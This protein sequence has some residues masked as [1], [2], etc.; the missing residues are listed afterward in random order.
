MK[1]LLPLA[2]LMMF[3][4]NASAENTIFLPFLPQVGDYTITRDNNGFTEKYRIASINEERDTYHVLAFAIRHDGTEAPRGITNRIGTTIR[5]LYINDIETYCEK[6]QGV[7]EKISV[8]AGDFEACRVDEGE[9]RPSSTWYA[10]WVPF[11]IVRISRA[12]TDSSPAYDRQLIE[13][14]GNR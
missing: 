1:R 2:M 7:R 8:P 10:P 3:G 14:G 6:R 5:S 9:T 4:A 11:G 12:A 13:F